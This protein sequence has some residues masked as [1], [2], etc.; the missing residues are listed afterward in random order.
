MEGEEDSFIVSESDDDNDLSLFVSIGYCPDFVWDRENY[1]SDEYAC[2]DSGSER[3]QSSS[4][5]RR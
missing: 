1:S 3:W 2:R 4:S 5:K